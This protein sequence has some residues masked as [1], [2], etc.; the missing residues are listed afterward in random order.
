MPVKTVMQI[1]P[2]YRKALRSAGLNRF[3]DFMAMT[4]GPPTSR[5]RHRETLP[6]EIDIDGTRRSFFLKRVFKV[7]PKHAV[8]PWLRFRG[9]RSQPR[10]EWEVLGVLGGRGIPAMVRVAHGEKRSWGRPV[11]AFLLVE[12]VPIQ[13]T[14]ENW[15]VPGFSR[16]GCLNAGQRSRLE[17]ETG[18]LVGRLHAEG[19]C[20]PDIQAKHI[21]AQPTAGRS[22]AYWEFCLIDVERMTRQTGSA[23][24]G[25]DR[26]SD[27]RSARE[28]ARLRKSLGPLA[29]SNSQIRRFL[30]GYCSGLGRR[31]RRAM[32][33]QE[34]GILSRG[35]MKSAVA[36]RLPDDYE[37]PRSTRLSR[38]GGMYL[39]S[40]ISAVLELAGLDS[41]KDVLEFRNGEALGKPGLPPHRNR[42]RL[43]LTDGDGPDRT[44]YLKRFH[45]PPIGEQL[46]RVRESEPFRGS[47]WP[48]VRFSKRLAELGIPAVRSVAFGQRM[49][50]FWELDSFAMSEAIDGES[51]ESVAD[52][53]SADPSCV[54]N[55]RDRRDIIVQ[56]ALITRAL[57]ANHLFHRDLYLCH[58]F[59]TRNRDGGIVLRLIDLARMIDRT[60]R[61]RRWSIKDL[62]SLDFSAP[63]GLVTRADRL[64]FLYTYDTALAAAGPGRRRRERLREWV[65]PII[66]R[67]DR[68][69]RHDAKRVRVLSRETKDGG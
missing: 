11:R 62:A 19:F 61:V 42:S 5:H 3:D 56:L 29:P 28:L 60:R 1:E 13:D 63:V 49:R 15:L 8:V 64:R 12:T 10:R 59:L 38:S 14:L 23:G 45:R 33:A 57:H 22:G 66:A 46:R 54:P 6:V 55:W 65:D 17:Y 53:A 48:E 26:R 69:A 43:R 35:A 21:F 16:P 30:A 20:W 36:P 27:P 44:F 52:R 41:L 9:G 50:W 31:M 24:E 58:V 25:V 18:H 32:L 51:L 40:R 68:V 34:K 67:V 39:D 4:G 7:P 2:S 47:A 37:H